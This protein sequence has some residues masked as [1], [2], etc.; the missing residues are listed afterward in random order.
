[1]PDL[2]QGSEQ[3]HDQRRGMV[4]AS[5][6]GQLISVGYLGA[7]SFWCDE[8]DAEPD[9]PCRS[10]VKRAGEYGTIKTF[11]SGRTALAE[12]SR[13]RLIEPARN[14]FSRGLTTLLAA[15]RI[16]GFTEPTYVSDDMWRGVESEP[17]A[18]DLYSEHFAPVHEVGFMVRQE[19]GWKLGYSPDGLVG[20][21]GLIE[22]KAPRSKKQLA[23]ILA[24]QVPAENLPQCQAGLLVSGRKWLDFVSYNG[25]MPLFVTRVFPDPKWFDAIT[26]AVQQFEQTAAEMTARY[27]VA[28]IGLPMTE[29]VETEMVI[30]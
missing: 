5:V 28:I 19:D 2:E 7:G 20:D 29:R 30:N 4:T 26:A 1:M 18:R 14:D 13:T 25:G 8:C 11:H 24:G 6:V 27:Q 3:W 23:T 12:S 10:K 9:D 16:T 17:I 21:D 15:E 22:I